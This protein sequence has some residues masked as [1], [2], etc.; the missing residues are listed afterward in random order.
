MDLEEIIRI[1]P[2]MNPWWSSGSVPSWA[3]PETRRK[4]FHDL[5]KAVQQERIPV[6]AGLRRSGKTTIMYQAIEELIHQGVPPKNIIFTS[7]DNLAFQD[8]GPEAIIDVME[9]HRQLAG[10]VDEGSSYYFFDEVQYI[11]DWARA[12]KTVWDRKTGD[13]YVVSGS[14]GLIVKGA[15]GESLVG[16]A[17]TLELGPWDLE[18]WTRLSGSDATGVGFLEL[19]DGPSPLESVGGLQG[20]DAL[21]RM[22][23][24]RVA[25]YLVVGGLPQAAMTEEAIPYLKYLFEDV[26][27]RVLFRD[28]PSMYDIRRP[29]KLARLLY[30]IAD[31][32]G[33]PLTV[34]GLAKALGLR[35]ETVE[36]YIEHLLA[37]RVVLELY[38]LGS[39]YVRSRSGR[40]FYL[41]DTG[42]Q[43][44]VMNKDTGILSDPQDMG[45]LAE[46][47]VAVHLSRLA[48]RHWA[49]LSFGHRHKGTEV[50]FVLEKGGALYVFE[51]KYKGS[52][53]PRELRSVA[54]YAE[55]VRARRAIVVTRD[56][57]DERE[58]CL[59]LPLWLFL[60]T[61]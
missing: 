15:S 14:A 8:M 52:P 23:S 31:K 43:N 4:E 58:G 46:Q 41:A 13:R 36:S 16:R 29:S 11:P 40:K 9:A 10:P 54:R 60:M 56:T 17:T 44:A 20:L 26:V 18:D 30:V 1:L 61:E 47:A 50:D 27:E 33:H 32:S 38:P 49:R 22:V 45:H 39:E 12:L 35:H 25:R 19:M 34:D 21:R 51:G 48:R 53:R 59:L 42:I 6:L 24:D 7:M 3:A 28:I 37:S 5:M 2:V 55:G 57:F